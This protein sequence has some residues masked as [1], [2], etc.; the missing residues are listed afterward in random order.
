MRALERNTILM[1][2]LCMPLANCARGEPEPARGSQSI[3]ADVLI[4][5]A[6]QTPREKH[7][8]LQGS[9]IE[10]TL[11]VVP[12]NSSRSFSVPSAAGDSTSELRLEAREPR[13]AAGLRS[14]VFLLSSGK[15][16]VWTLNEAGQGLLVNR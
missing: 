13:Q 12:G 6:N 16:V 7:I 8:F 14:S 4:S 10:H 15:R 5:V 2:V 9:A 1:T 11:G 3:V